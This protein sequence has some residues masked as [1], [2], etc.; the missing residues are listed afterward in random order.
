MSMSKS[1]YRSMSILCPCPS[2]SISLFMVVSLSASGLFQDHVMCGLCH[3][4][5]NKDNFQDMDLYTEMDTDTDMNTDKK[6]TW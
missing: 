4:C 6:R 3:A 1:V 5:F 2:V